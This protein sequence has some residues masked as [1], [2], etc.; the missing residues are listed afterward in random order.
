MLVTSQAQYSTNEVVLLSYLT[1]SMLMSDDLRLPRRGIEPES[2]GFWEVGS[3]ARPLPLPCKNWFKQKPA[4]GGLGSAVS[5]STGVLGGTPR[6]WRFWYISDWIGIMYGIRRVHS[7]IAF[8][9]L[10]DTAQYHQVVTIYGNN[11]VLYWVKLPT[12]F[13]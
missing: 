8:P 3:T 5:S 4:I 1:C 13:V 2:S 9:S 7:L 6:R 12:V 11:S 10:N